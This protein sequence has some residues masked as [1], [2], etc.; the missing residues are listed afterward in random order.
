MWVSGLSTEVVEPCSITTQSPSPSIHHI[1]RARTDSFTPHVPLDPGD[2]MSH[3][4]PQP[5]PFSPP[6]GPPATRPA[7]KWAR[8]RFVLPALVLA[9]ALGAAGAGAD[10][11]NTNT[12]TTKTTAADKA[13]PTATATVTATA[14]AT[15]TAKPEPAPTVTKTVTVPI[16]V[17]TLSHRT[18]PLAADHHGSRCAFPQEGRESPAT[19][20]HLRG[21]TQGP[22]PRCFLIFRSV[23]LQR[24][25]PEGHAGYRLSDQSK[26]RVAHGRASTTPP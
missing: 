12:D 11:G 6:P 14:T 13:E 9:F 8:K 26:N 23:A 15:E 2:P 5:S 10:S 25:V 17:P 3:Y 21:V 22:A 4:P 16:V 18:P 1:R 19:S 7:P 20:D 24:S